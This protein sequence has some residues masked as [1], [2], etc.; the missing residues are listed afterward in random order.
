V[1]NLPEKY[2]YQK[3]KNHKELFSS[4]MGV[5]NEKRCNIIQ[6]MI[7][8]CL[9]T[10]I[11]NAINMGTSMANSARGLIHHVL[12]PCPPHPTVHFFKLLL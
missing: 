12:A 4:K 11:A 2:V 7:G 6:F 5:L 9:N 1:F 3:N 10:G 8:Q